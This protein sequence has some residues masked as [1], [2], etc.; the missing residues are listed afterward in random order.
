MGYR[1]YPYSS[2]ILALIILLPVLAYCTFLI[3]CHSEAKETLIGSKGRITINYTNKKAG[4]SWNF[5]RDIKWKLS[6]VKEVKTDLP[7]HISLR[8][9]NAGLLVLNYKHS[10]IQI[11]DSALKVIGTFGKKGKDSMSQND[12][13][14]HF[15]CEEGK[16]SLYDFGSKAV[17][18]FDLKSGKLTDYSLFAHPAGIYRVGHLFGKRYVYVQPRDSTD[19]DINFI[20]F[21][22]S[23]TKV[24]RT[25]SLN[26][27]LNITDRKE[28]PS[29]AYDGNFV[30]EAGSDYIVYYCSFGGNF[31]CF[32]KHET[33]IAFSRKTIDKTPV[34]L[35]QYVEISPL[36]KALEISPNIMFFPDA[37]LFKN[38]LYLLNNINSTKEYVADIYELSDNGA[39]DGSFFIPQSSSGKKP[40]SIAVSG[41][42]IYVLYEDQ[43]IV[44]Y[45]IDPQ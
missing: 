4:Y 11:L 18:Q 25:Y 43:K 28:Y 7:G 14:L 38:K 21:D 34:P 10:E 3:S 12:G 9:T 41:E 29:M 45:A 42:K 32:S 26:K 8:W 20:F 37:C 16:L 2:K 15:D 35:A 33:G 1:L 39:Y 13:I 44:S 27:L 31:I 30:T 5:V 23:E 24:L 36:H 40:L 22:S 19:Q 17:K 6:L